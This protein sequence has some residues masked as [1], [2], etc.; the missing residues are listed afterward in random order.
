MRLKTFFPSILFSLFFNSLIAQ[1]SIQIPQSNYVLTFTNKIDCNPI[2]DQA[3]TG[4]CWSFSTSSFVE[5]EMA[6]SNKEIVDLSEMFFVRMTYMDK[7]Q[8]Y[9]RTH[10]K[11]NFGE[12]GLGHDVLRMYKKYGAVPEEVY[13]GLIDGKTRHSHGE[14]IRELNAYLD[15]EIRSGSID[16]SWEQQVNLI[17]D[18]HLG[19]LPKSFS[20]AGREYTPRSF[21]ETHVGINPEDYIT[22]TSFSCYP[23]NEEVI[24][25]I[26]DNYANQPYL[27]VNIEDLILIIDSAI[28]RNYS[29]VWDC[30]VSDRGFS[31]ARGLAI[32]PDV[33]Y[34][35]I[36]EVNEAFRMPGNEKSVTDR[37]R[38]FEFDTY[39]LTD[40]HLMHIIGRAEDQIGT[41]YYFVKNSWGDRP[42][43][44]GYLFASSGY[45][46]KNTIGILI[47]KD[48]L[49]QS[50]RSKILVSPY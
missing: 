7:A 35:E 1:E 33:D 41:V 16:T 10:G 32:Y 27:N 24:L 22:W 42:G 6:R 12:G 21:A 43:L 11:S 38:Q 46:Q 44:D 50:V 29:I 28:S 19:V 36:S 48:A 47:H 30:D 2:E 5:T 17:L 31:S 20:Y 13:T 14:L 26:P 9:I 18:A 3:S 4:T 49:P 39:T 45:V 34:N 40:D 8:K 37:S 23:M 15:K 25:E